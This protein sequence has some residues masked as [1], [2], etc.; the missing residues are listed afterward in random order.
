MTA[1]RT[2][3][4]GRKP[5]LRAR[6]LAKCVAEE[7]ETQI[8]KRDQHDC[9][10]K[11]KQRKRL[12]PLKQSERNENAEYGNRDAATPQP[13]LVCLGSAAGPKPRSDSKHNPRDHEHG[14]VRFH[15]SGF[16]RPS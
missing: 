14:N 6:G 3:V 7:R 5:V 9:G 1:S 15:R 8:Q 12:M 11:N 13:F 2:V 10:D 16:H 4:G